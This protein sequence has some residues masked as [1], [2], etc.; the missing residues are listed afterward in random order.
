MDDDELKR[1]GKGCAWLCE[2]EQN[3]GRPPRETF[4]LQLAEARA[5]WRRRHQ[6]KTES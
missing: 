3:H 4:V 6:G 2:P 5:E 1:H